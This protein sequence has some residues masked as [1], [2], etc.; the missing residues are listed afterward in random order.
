MKQC[1][2]KG[3]SHSPASL[4]KEAQQGGEVWGGI[5]PVSPDTEPARVTI[6]A[7]SASRMMGNKTV[8][9]FGLLI[10]QSIF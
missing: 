2:Y 8:K 10:M 1:S 5:N 6:W 7:F 9:L 4:P 3:S